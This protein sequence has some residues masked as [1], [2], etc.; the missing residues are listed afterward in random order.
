MMLADD[1]DLMI[2]VDDNDLIMWCFISFGFDGIEVFSELQFAG[3]VDGDFYGFRYLAYGFECF[4]CFGFVDS[5][6]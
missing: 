5:F 6:F 3:L 4:C 1:N 2:L